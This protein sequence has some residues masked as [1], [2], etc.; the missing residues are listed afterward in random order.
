MLSGCHFLV[1]S[2]A[3]LSQFQ[4]Y[5]SCYCLQI[6]QSQQWGGEV[7]W[8]SACEGVE[9]FSPSA[10]QIL[11]SFVRSSDR[12]LFFLWYAHIRVA[13]SPP[14]K[15]LHM[16]EE[17]LP[18]ADYLKWCWHIGI[19]PGMLREGLVQ[20]LCCSPPSLLAAVLWAQTCSRS[21]KNRKSHLFQHSE[22]YR[23]RLH[24]HQ[25][26]KIPRCNWWG[27]MRAHMWSWILA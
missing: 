10:V 22:F 2:F 12:Y 18:R 19:T 4:S 25:L 11:H 9:K 14:A 20:A 7:L 6:N 13:S 3:H 5:K 24:C 27:S 8:G 15:W 17:P 16:W 26:I 1:I 21:V 23:N